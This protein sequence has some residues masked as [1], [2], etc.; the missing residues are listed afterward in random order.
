MT[1]R[2][3]L[4]DPSADEPTAS[5]AAASSG[6]N[7]VTPR[8]EAGDS[9]GEG[10]WVGGRRRYAAT[11]SPVKM[12]SATQTSEKPTHRRA[13]IGSEKTTTPKK[14][15]IVGAMY[16]SIPSVVSETRLADPA[17]HSSGAAVI[18]PVPASR[19]MWTG[20]WPHAVLWPVTVSPRDVA[21][22]DRC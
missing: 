14:S 22:R 19:R 9:S 6:G 11:E 4:G 2:R 13:P 8:R 17:K 20:P 12:A 1:P 5:Y 16:W 18:T 7:E 15:W 3:E 10:W 21:E